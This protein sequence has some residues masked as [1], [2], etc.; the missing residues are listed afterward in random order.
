MPPG[1]RNGLFHFSQP[2][3]S[4]S[5]AERP[6]SFSQPALR[7]DCTGCPCSPGGAAVAKGNCTATA[8][9]ND[10]L[11]QAAL[12]I[13]QVLR[14]R[15]PS[16]AEHTRPSLRWPRSWC[17]APL[18]PRSL[19]SAGASEVALAAEQ[20]SWAG[21]VPEGEQ[22]TGTWRRSWQRGHAWS[23]SNTE[24]EM[25]QPGPRGPLLRPRVSPDQR[26]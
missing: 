22:A 18:L 25:A 14:R 19:L 8:G 7:P 11:S 13:A 17:V 9:P 23:D 15:E 10:A 1:N 2:E 3:S 4:A 12:P 20:P 6:R 26:W 5:G 21:W 24:P 16:S